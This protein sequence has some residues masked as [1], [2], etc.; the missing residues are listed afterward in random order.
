MAITEAKN[1]VNINT[2]KIEFIC[3]VCKA[4]KFLDVP[5]SVIAEAKQL[6]TMSIAR[7]LV[8][9]HQFQA[10]VDKNYQVRGYQRVDFEIENNKNQANNSNVS[11]SR[12]DENGF[13]DNLVLEGNYLE[14]KPKEIQNNQRDI[15]KNENLNFQKKDMSLED[16]YNEFWEFIDENNEEFRFFINKDLRRNQNPLLY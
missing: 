3:P 12:K 15:L 7:G 9:S 5:K 2:S 10:F 6:T 13:F 14:Y 4:K 8:C 1:N 16:I 11:Y